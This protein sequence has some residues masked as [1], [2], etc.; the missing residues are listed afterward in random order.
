MTS[1][2]NPQ[3]AGG[4]GGGSSRGRGGGTLSLYTKGGKNG[5]KVEGKDRRMGRGWVGAGLKLGMKG[6]PWGMRR[7]VGGNEGWRENHGE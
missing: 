7:S 5:K 3:C 2:I 4:R 1:E 6:E